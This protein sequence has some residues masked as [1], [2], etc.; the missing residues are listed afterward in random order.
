MQ[1][2]TP[3]GVR[4]YG[5]SEAI[6]LRYIAGVVEEVFKRFGFYPIE[7]PAIENTAVLNAKAYGEESNKEIYILEGEAAGLR[8]DLTVPLARFVASN[9]S[10]VLPF[11]RYQ[12]GAIWRK[13]EPQRMRYREFMQADLDVVGSAE[14]DCEAEVIAAPLIA[15]EELGIRDY[16]LLINS[17][18]LLQAILKSFGVPEAKEVAAI[19]IIDKLQKLGREAVQ[20]QL[21]GLGVDTKACEQLLGFIEDD[22][23]NGE[24][25]ARLS[26]AVE[27]TKDEAG[28]MSR[29]I[30]MLGAYG[31]GGKVIVDFS[32]A[33]G[34]DYYTGFVWE[35]AMMENGKRLPSIGSGGRYDNLVGAYSSKSLPAV[36]SSIGITRVFDL[37]GAKSMMKTQAGVFVAFIGDN[38]GYAVSVA[39]TLRG[40]GIYADL[41]CMRRNLSKQLEYAGAMGIKHVAIIGDKERLANK[42]NLRNMISG[43]EEMLTIEEVVAEL[44][45]K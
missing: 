26:A 6:S 45:K 10:L 37:I 11:K 13:D 35:F 31:L 29:L 34:L 30:E 25:L 41:N 16:V 27:G 38:R 20:K 24:K 28:N 39:N 43:A 32:L 9:R 18:K 4:D 1:P 14:L 23:D 40:N 5:P 33:R 7:T 12:L 19:R 36:G 8:Y 3:R 21:E 15:L 22:G 2:S 17:R 42:I 44:K